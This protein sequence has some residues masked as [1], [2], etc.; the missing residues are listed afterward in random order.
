LQTRFKQ[1]ASSLLIA[2]LAVLLLG[3]SIWFIYI[4]FISE[5]P[6]PANLQL[7]TGNAITVVNILSHFNVFLITLLLKH[8]YDALRWSL[9]SRSG[10]VSIPTFLALSS[11]TD[12]TGIAGL[13]RVQGWHQ[14][15]C[16]Q[17]FVPRAATCSVSWS[18][19]LNCP[20]SSL[21]IT[22]LLS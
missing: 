11:A 21:K 4:E 10:G 18:L 15:L 16:I 1:H 8:A 9:A 3:F 17:R 20:Q 12:L 7:S 2:I 19:I 13:L 14:L 6:L 22:L 5:K